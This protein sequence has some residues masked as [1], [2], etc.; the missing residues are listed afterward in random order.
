[1]WNSY[2]KKAYLPASLGSRDWLEY[3]QQDISTGYGCISRGLRFTSRWAAEK[4]YLFQ[5]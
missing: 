3:L 2:M 4:R 1:M 5:E